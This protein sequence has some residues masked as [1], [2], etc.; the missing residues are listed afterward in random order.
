M[1]TPCVLSLAV[2]KEHDGEDGERNE[3]ADLFRGP[4]LYQFRQSLQT[5]RSPVADVRH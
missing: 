1:I 3:Y 4:V 5:A 2:K